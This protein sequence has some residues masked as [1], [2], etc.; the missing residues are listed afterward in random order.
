V[1]QGMIGDD[2]PVRRAAQR[3]VLVV[4]AGALGAAVCSTAV[5]VAAPA[6]DET[7]RAAPASDLPS[8]SSGPISPAE[9]E[10]LSLLGRAAEAEAGTA[11]TGQKLFGSWS[12]S[13]GDASVIADVRHVP[14]QGTWVRVTTAGAGEPHAEIQEA[15]AALDP[16]ALALLTDRYRLRVA[17][18]EE[19]LGRS[20]TVIEASPRGSDR[21]AGRYW[22]DDDTGLLL[23][24]VLYD[25]SGRQIRAASF[26]DI[27][28]TALA[29]TPAHRYGRPQPAVLPSA[30]PTRDRSAAD[31]GRELDEDEVDALRRG[32]WVL[33]AAL[34]A[35]LVLYRAGVVE[36][37]SG[38]TIVQLT[39]SDGLFAVSL[40]AQRGRLDT[41]ALD[42][43]EPDRLGN[44]DVH[45]RPGLYRQLVWAGGNT[46]Y[47][48]VSD[49]PDP[50]L[51]EV[52]AA[53]PHRAPDAG[54]LSRMGRGIDRMG[55]WINPF[56]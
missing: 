18:T 36:R 51:A 52:V 38:R 53:L 9:R 6:D 14:G 39:Y 43:F 37:G 49:A 33:P 47:T 3:F 32:G 55:S 15:D 41:D 21:V 8:R 23:R 20:V 2:H 25:A 34:P 10:A 45:S 19:C 5:L 56:A 35:G 24:R 54:L 7:V 13:G 44:V 30:Q 1:I 50:A 11:Y 48:L 17:D 28:I 12:S 4:G 27:T 46:V 42:G 26:L 31:D 40:F 16:H 29:S 22:L